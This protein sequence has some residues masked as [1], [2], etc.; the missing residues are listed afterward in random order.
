MHEGLRLVIGVQVSAF[1]AEHQSDQGD[2]WRVEW[3]SK[4]KAWLR[5]MSVRF[6]HKAT[7]VGLSSHNK[8]F[9]RPISGQTEIC[10]MRRP[11][12]NG[13]WKA[14]EGVYFPEHQDGDEDEHTEL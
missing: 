4:S 13:L 6:L 8:K 10:G 5:D 11:E 9:G 7:G 14:T 3:D 12:K 1:G 2:I